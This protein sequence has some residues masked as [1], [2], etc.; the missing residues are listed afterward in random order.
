L[1]KHLEKFSQMSKRFG[2][3]DIFQATLELI[4]FVSLR[5][6]RTVGMLFFFKPA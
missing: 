1:G 5:R 4:A 3:F 2:M 6:K